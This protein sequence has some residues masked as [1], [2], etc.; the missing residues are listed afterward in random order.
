M[1]ARGLVLRVVA[2]QE[3]VGAAEVADVLHAGP[4]SGHARR[5]D[6]SDGVQVLFTR[7]PFSLDFKKMK[8]IVKSSKN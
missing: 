5:V 3:G 8:K 2:E 1:V 6:D 7:I 4:P